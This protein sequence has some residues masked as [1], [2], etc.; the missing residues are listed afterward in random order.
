MTAKHFVV[1]DV[2]GQCHGS[3]VCAVDDT[4]VVAW[5]AGDHEGAANSRIWLATGAGAAWSAPVVVSGD[6]APCWNPVLHRR[7]DGDLVCWFKVGTT[8]S[9]WV[10]YAVTSAD[11]GRTWSTPRRVGEPGGRGPVRTPP[12]RLRSGRLLAGA[13]TE[14]WGE[15]PRWDCFVDLSDDD[16]RTWRRRPDI[17]LDHD[18]FPGAGAIQPALW[19][20]PDGTVRL[21]ARSTAGRLVAASSDD[22]GETWTPG[23]L[24]GVP[25]NNSGIAVARLGGTVYLAHNPTVGD[26][27]SRAP[28]VVS[29][30]TDEGETFQPWLTLEESLGET[31]GEGYR[32]A[33][34][35]VLTTGDNEFSYPCLV[36]VGDRLVVTYTWQRRGI[37]LALLDPSERTP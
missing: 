10:T 8:I 20:T 25:N 2:P 28:L 34:S 22:E 32:P 17:A 7:T 3:T 4:L 9:A 27:A 31:A 1:R 19:Q 16:G 37:V 23:M 33:D 12:L 6:L 13:S 21:L 36:P 11:G 29:T 30:S 26:W 5:F 24:S 14:T 15:R 35:G 18:T